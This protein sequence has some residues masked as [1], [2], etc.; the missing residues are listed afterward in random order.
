MKINLSPQRRDDPLVVV[1]AGSVLT[2][3]GAVFDLSQMGNGDTLPRS[4]IASEWLTSDVDK[5]GGELTLTLLLP[6]PWNYSPEQAFPQPLLNVPDG[7]V[8]FPLPLP[9]ESGGYPPLPPL[10][11]VIGSGAIDWAQLV[12]QAMK[13]AVLLAAQLAAAT[14]ELNARV[15]VGNAQ[16]LALNGRIATLNWLIDEQDPEDPDYMEPTAEDIA[17]R[18][19]LK[20]LLLKW[21]SYNAK[22]GK[23]KTQATWPTAPVWPVAPALYVE[24]TSANKAIAAPTI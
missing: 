11:P 23:M 10:P 22:L 1:R 18:T 13:D 12:T 24:N 6:I 20:A 19:A 21:N 15:R 14:A 8:V 5:V 9:D 2:I 17:E 7:R 4:A 3:N 16:A